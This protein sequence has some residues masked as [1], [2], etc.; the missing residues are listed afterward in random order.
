MRMDDASSACEPNVMV[1]K[2]ARETVRSVCL[3]VRVSMRL[4]ERY[5][6]FCL[7]R[8]FVRRWSVDGRYFGAHGPEIGCE[9]APM[10]NGV[11]QDKP[12]KRTHRLLGHH[13]AVVIELRRAI[14]CGFVQLRDALAELVRQA[15]EQ[16]DHLVERRRRKS[17]PLGSILLDDIQA[18]FEFV[19]DGPDELFGRRRR[20]SGL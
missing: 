15:L 9:L 11:E 4:R 1:P 16:D 5:S 17:F 7:R 14:P 8:L 10:M 2:Q 13:L 3:R 12:E 20:F 19:R 18:Q 6:I